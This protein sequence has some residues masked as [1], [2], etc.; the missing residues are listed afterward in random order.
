M[1]Q[2]PIAIEFL[3][4]YSNE[5]KI[6]KRVSFK[7]QQSLSVNCFSEA[8]KYERIIHFNSKYKYDITVMS[9]FL[10]LLRFFTF[11]QDNKQK[12]IPLEK[13]YRVVFAMHCHAS[14]GINVLTF[15]IQVHVPHMNLVIW[16]S[17]DAKWYQGI[18]RYSADYNVW[19]FSFI[20]FILI[21]DFILAFSGQITFI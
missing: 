11:V 1:W 19:F 14:S 5:M 21:Y 8:Q 6:S 10:K 18:S 3:N 4:W 20:I 16:M 2:R 12:I 17:A 9:S 13:K 15:K 7:Y